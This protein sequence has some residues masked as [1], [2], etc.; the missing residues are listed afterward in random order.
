MDRGGVDCG[1]WHHLPPC[2]AMTHQ[3][4]MHT[5]T[6]KPLRLSVCMSH[7]GSFESGL[8]AL[9]PADPSCAVRG[10]PGGSSVSLPMIHGAWTD[11][12]SR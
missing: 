8:E 7:H 12:M 1:G 2:I 9:L 5:I 11:P 6:N 10:G 4:T 3:A